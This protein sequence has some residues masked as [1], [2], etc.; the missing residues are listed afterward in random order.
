MLRITLLLLL[1]G[2]LAQADITGRVVAVTDGDTIKVL[3]ATT[4]STKFA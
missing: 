2:S 3:D 4:P 1:F